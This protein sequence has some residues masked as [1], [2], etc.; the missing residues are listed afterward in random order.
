ME[1]MGTAPTLST[2]TVDATPVGTAGQRQ[3]KAAQIDPN[4]AKPPEHTRLLNWC[5]QES[6]CADSTGFALQ[7]DTHRGSCTGLFY[8]ITPPTASGADSDIS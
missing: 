3:V 2:H 8:S 5:E 6:I 7:R 1:N 4:N